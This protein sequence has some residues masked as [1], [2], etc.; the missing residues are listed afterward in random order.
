[1]INALQVLSAFKC[2]HKRRAYWLYHHEVVDTPIMTSCRNVYKRHGH[3]FD[4]FFQM[5]SEGFFGRATY[6]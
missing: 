3:A 1:M 6:S 2:I 4:R 5:T